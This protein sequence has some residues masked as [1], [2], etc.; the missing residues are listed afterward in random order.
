MAQEAS[1]GGGRQRCR[2]GRPSCTGWRQTG[3]THPEEKGA[4]GVT[5]I[6][7][8][9]KTVRSYGF[10]PSGGPLRRAAPWEVTR[11]RSTIEAPHSA[12]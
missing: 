12:H 4:P 11:L 7:P 9:P 2:L 6:P 8:G 3:Q 1:Q 5:V 10:S